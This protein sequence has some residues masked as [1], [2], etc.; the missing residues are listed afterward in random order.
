MIREEVIDGVVFVAQTTF[1]V[2]GDKEAR[3]KDEHM[4]VTSDRKLFNRQKYWAKNRIYKN[5]D[6]NQRI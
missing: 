4:L 1:Y 3:E 6:A 2:Y 5:P